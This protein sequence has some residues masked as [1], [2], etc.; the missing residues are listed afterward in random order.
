MH[1]IS[2][3][4][5]AKRA[6]RSTPA[7]RVPRVKRATLT[8]LPEN[9]VVSGLET[10]DVVITPE[11]IKALYQVP[12]ATKADP[13]NALGIFE[14]QVYAGSYYQASLDGFFTD[15][16]PEIPNGTHPN[17]ASIGGGVAPSIPVIEQEGNTTYLVP[18][19]VEADLDIEIAYPLI[20]PQNITVFQ[21]GQT[22]ENFT[23]TV[24]FNTFLDSIDGS[25]CTFSAYGETGNDPDWDP[26]YPGSFVNYTG[27][28]QCGIY[29]APNVVSFSYSVAESN[30]PFNYQKRQCDEYMKLG[31]QGTTLVFSSGDY[32]HSGRPAYQNGTFVA[33]CLGPE[34]TIFNPHFPDCPWLTSVGATQV[35]P[36]HT[37]SEPQPE[38]AA[39]WPGVAGLFPNGTSGGGFS[40]IY[41]I[42]EY[43]KDALDTYFRDHDPGL[44]YYEGDEP[45]GANG[46]VYNRSG[47]G[48]PDGEITSMFRAV[49]L[50]PPFEFP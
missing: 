20:Y 49:S 11:C 18:D 3:G 46:G 45:L 36:G 44:P 5:Q 6:K 10:C 48:Y 17:T 1:S 9:T 4:V 12:N 40:N 19:N 43:Q 34:E 35:Y 27:A 29:K 15:Y 41:P 22:S 8:V 28:E 50:I 7:A 14:E 25:Y 16:Y 30:L 33:V 37:V 13:S 23:G 21:I 24:M 31:L 47:R 38:S 2:Q 26:T 42:P 39:F 32:G